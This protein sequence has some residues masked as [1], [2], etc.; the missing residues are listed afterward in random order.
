MQ[1]KV[2]RK[3]YTPNSTIGV[4][5]V[6]GVKA[7]FSLEDTKRE[8]GVKVDGKTAIPAG[9]YDVIIDYSTR[10]KKLMPH[11]I[12]VPGFVGV[13]IHK[14]NTE[15]DTEGC[16]LVGM[17]KGVDEIYNCQGIFDYIFTS[18]QYALDHKEPCTI[19]II[20]DSAL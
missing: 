1:I 6:N 9:E 14:G 5:S 15:F 13:R 19:W 20:N 8:D 12:N 7:G 2:L 17:N 10:F 18:I 16:I 3:W 11:I 4:V